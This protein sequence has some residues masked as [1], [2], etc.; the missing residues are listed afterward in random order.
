MEKTLAVQM[1]IRQNAE[2]I[3][4]ALKEVQGWEKNVRNKDRSLQNKGFVPVK[5][6]DG[7]RTAAGTVPIK[8]TPAVASSASKS[9]GQCLFLPVDSEV[10]GKSRLMMLL[11][12]VYCTDSS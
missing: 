9:S 11:N 3:S 5:V 6:R 4:N 10:A 2:E 7:V 12:R 8:S 1:Q